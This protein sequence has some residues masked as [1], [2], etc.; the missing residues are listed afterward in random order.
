[1]QE[2]QCLQPATLSRVPPTNA[3]PQTKIPSAFFLVLF[4]RKL[5][6]LAF[7]RE[8]DAIWICLLIHKYKTSAAAISCNMPQ[9]KEISTE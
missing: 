8:E 1:M 3:F 7:L 9:Q 5:D 2:D 6:S 4:H